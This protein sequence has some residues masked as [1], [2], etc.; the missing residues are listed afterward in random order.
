MQSGKTVQYAGYLVIIKQYALKGKY[1][2]IKKA[3]IIYRQNKPYTHK[4]TGRCK[5][6]WQQV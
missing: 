2:I 1:A 3:V 5:D 6:N 4:A